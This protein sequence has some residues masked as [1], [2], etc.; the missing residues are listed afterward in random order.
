[1]DVFGMGAQGITRCRRE[2][3]GFGRRRCGEIE[4]EIRRP[5]R[6]FGNMDGK[7]SFSGNMKILMML[8]SVLSKK[9]ENG[10]K[11]SPDDFRTQF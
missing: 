3:G 1:M 9:L 5:D 7:C 8:G 4:R 6:F 11:Y 10:V 2:I